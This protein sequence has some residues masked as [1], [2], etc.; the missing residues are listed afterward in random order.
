M[1]GISFHH[2]ALAFDE[3]YRLI[4][5]DLGLLCGIEVTYD[6]EGEGQ[7]RN[8]C[9]IVGGHKVPEERTTIVIKV[10]DDLKFQVVVFHHDVNLQLYMDNVVLFRRG[11][12]DI[13]NLFLKSAD[14]T[15]PRKPD[16]LLEHIHPA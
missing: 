14:S 5:K 13:E 7:R 12:A 16:V 3:Q 4:V 9:W 1:P 11:T 2:F 8:F 10:H 15:F 6:K